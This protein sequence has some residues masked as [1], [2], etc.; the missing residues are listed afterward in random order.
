MSELTCCFK[1]LLM[2][3]LSSS[4][5][6][7]TY[8]P[9]VHRERHWEGH[10]HCQWGQQAH[11]PDFPVDPVSPGTGFQLWNLPRAPGIQGGGGMW[12][13]PYSKGRAMERKVKTDD[14]PDLIEV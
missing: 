8:L 3:P 14:W 1:M 2:M 13:R 6:K 5:P 7:C 10:L 12:L 4:R 9:L 11:E